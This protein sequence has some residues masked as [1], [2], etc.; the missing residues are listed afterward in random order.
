MGMTK[1]CSAFRVDNAA[2]KIVLLRGQPRVQAAEEARDGAYQHLTGSGRL[3]LSPSNGAPELSDAVSLAAAQA[4]GSQGCSAAG[5]RAGAADTHA[6]TLSPLPDL[7][8]AADL[9]AGGSSSGRVLP[10]ETVTMG[11][12]GMR[13]GGAGAGARQTPAVERGYCFSTEVWS[14]PPGSVFCHT[15]VRAACAYGWVTPQRSRAAPAVHT[16]NPGG[17]ARQAHGEGLQGEMD[18]G[19]LRAQVWASKGARGISTLAAAI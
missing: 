6:D 1:Y 8:P 5:E 12:C 18:R 2:P 9:T 15:K 13:V 17:D 16:D 19:G 14:S 11:A 10:T 4:L 3:E 7:M